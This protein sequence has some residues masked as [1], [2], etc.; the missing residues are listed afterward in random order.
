MLAEAPS[1]NDEYG[2]SSH[3]TL[4]PGIT[5]RAS[6]CSENVL[7]GLVARDGVGKDGVV[8]TLVVGD[9]VAKIK[10][11]E[12][13]LDNALASPAKR[14][15]SHDGG[16]GVSKADALFC[17]TGKFLQLFLTPYVEFNCSYGAR[18]VLAVLALV[19]AAHLLVE[20]YIAE[21]SAE[22]HECY[23]LEH[24]S[25]LLGAKFATVVL[26]GDRAPTSYP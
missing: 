21:D 3:S 4:P 19:V 11:H 17:A 15:T 25:D 22:R 9:G 5:S 8:R 26:G 14:T 23:V 20:G 24:H 2:T 13:A 18:G 12:L 10:L 1:G 16:D 7:A 6:K